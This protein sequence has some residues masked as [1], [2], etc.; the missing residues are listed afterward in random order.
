MSR[1]TRGPKE[2]KNGVNGGHHAP[3][4]E[5]DAS[6]DPKI[7]R[8]TSSPAFDHWLERQTRHIVDASSRAPEQ[9]LIDL[10]RNW[11]GSTPKKD[12]GEITD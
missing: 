3:R 2:P 1:K 5:D 10:I 4:G 7:V 8:L 11:P 6:A 9:E 12:P